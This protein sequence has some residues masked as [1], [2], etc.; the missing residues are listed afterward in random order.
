MIPAPVSGP[1]ALWKDGLRVTRLC[2]QDGILWL[3]IVWRGK[4]VEVR[5]GARALE[6]ARVDR[7]PLPLEEMA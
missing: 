5:I 2:E 7:E 4:P 6:A 3:E 1:S